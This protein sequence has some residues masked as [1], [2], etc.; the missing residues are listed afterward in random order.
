[1]KIHN[2]TFDELIIYTGKIPLYILMGLLLSIF[3][4]C[5]IVCIY[6]KLTKPNSN[7][8]IPLIFLLSVFIIAIGSATYVSINSNYKDAQNNRYAFLN[9]DS[10][11]KVQAIN[12][13]DNAIIN[14]ENASYI[15]TLPKNVHAKKGDTLHI[16][17]HNKSLLLDREDKVIELRQQDENKNI[18]KIKET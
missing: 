3:L 14:I 15:L 12:S 5:L 18:I 2:L 6:I 9:M 7:N 10:D 4:I 16:K 1:M 8:V 13:N 11:I 17:V